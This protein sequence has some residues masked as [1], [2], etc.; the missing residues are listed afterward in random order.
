MKKLIS[1]FAAVILVLSAFAAIPA[2][3]AE[4]VL[5]SQN[6]D[7][8]AT[9]ADAGFPDV[10]SRSSGATPFAG[11]LSIVDGKLKATT[12]AANSKLY[13]FAFLDGGALSDCES[14]TVAFD[15]YSMH[16]GKN[17]AGTD[18][19]VGLSFE[20]NPETTDTYSTVQFAG[21][22]FNLAY[23][24][25]QVAGKW[26]RAKADYRYDMETKGI[27]TGLSTA[28]AIISHHITCTVDRVAKTISYTVDG[29]L[30][31]EN[32][33]LEATYGGA[34]SLLIYGKNVEA[35]FDNIVVTG[36]NSKP[37][38]T[39]P[40]PVTTEAPVETSAPAAETTAPA[41][42][43][44]EAPVSPDTGDAGV[45]VAAAVCIIMLTGSALLIVKRRKEN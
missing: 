3:A 9:P 29:V 41:G 44:T 13:W 12:E 32:V 10:D 1:I 33:P 36:Y 27:K 11:T 2:S 16:G 34:L 18:W 4:V 42:E 28:D 26:S 21:S 35:Y 20:W 24:S 6:F 7:G 30:M 8:V 14:Y 22:A 15:V 17:S 39:A 31:E 38:T 5:Y 45:L 40:A 25:S 43:T 19:A 23:A 37:E